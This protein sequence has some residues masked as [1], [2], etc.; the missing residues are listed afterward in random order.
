MKKNRVFLTAALATSLILTPI[1]AACSSSSVSAA[2]VTSI[3][4]KV[5]CVCGGCDLTVITCNDNAGQACATA[6][7][8]VVLIRKGLAAGHSQEQ[9]L[10][11]MVGVYGQRALVQ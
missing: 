10:K 2:A 9:V 7:K 8:Q 6:N 11:D 5:N 3:G 1:L 4:L